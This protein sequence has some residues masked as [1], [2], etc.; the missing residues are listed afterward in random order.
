MTDNS[1]AIHLMA[2]QRPDGQLIFEQVLAKPVGD[3]C[4]ELLTSPLFARG[5]ARGD[6]VRVLVAG[7]FEVEQYGGNLC[8]RVM[9]RRDLGAIASLLESQFKDLGG[10]KDFCND[11]MAVFSVPVAAGFS[12]IEDLLNLALKQYGD[13]AQWL[14]ANVYD[15]LDGETP[16]NWWHDFLAK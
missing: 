14:Y 10:Q 3:E 11:R 2:G 13:D 7:R 8:I 4:Y 1:T 15:P 16:L 9:A 6:I 5:T 12:V